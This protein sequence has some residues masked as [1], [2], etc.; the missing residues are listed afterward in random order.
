MFI[1]HYGPAFIAATSRRSPRLGSL[2]IAAQ[3]VDISFFSLLLLG[4]E[5]MRLVPG[6]TKMNPMDLYDMPWT[7]SLVG[8]LGWSA[9]FALL[10]WL[11]R[12]NTMAA[13]IGGAVVLSHWLLD[14]LVHRPDLTIA[15]SPP[16]LGLGLWNHPGIEIPLELALA[17]GGLAWFAARTRGRDWQGHV[18]IVAL[19]VALAAF[20]AINWL[21]AQ[22]ATMVDPAPSTVPVT[23]L[24]AYAVLAAIAWWV[25]I[26]RPIRAS[27]NTDR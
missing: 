12:R 5:H 19:A 15:G 7:H 25:G 27:T 23:G 24:F 11:W 2:F 16:P 20:Q 8:A 13:L 21:A 9:G 14:L 6:A 22:P 18:S 10:L 3:L 26:A 4:V 1:G 17:F